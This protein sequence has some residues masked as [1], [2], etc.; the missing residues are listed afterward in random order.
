MEQES[1]SLC[2][3]AVCVFV[4]LKFVW[5]YCNILITTKA[6]FIM[7]TF[8]LCVVLMQMA[9]GMVFVHHLCSSSLKLLLTVDVL[10]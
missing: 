1:V 3:F 9:D 5:S 7:L 6:E 8:L 10:V 4:L 2:T